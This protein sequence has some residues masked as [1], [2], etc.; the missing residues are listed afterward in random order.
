MPGPEQAHGQ[1]H[2]RRHPDLRRRC[3]RGAAGQALFELLTAWTLHARAVTAKRNK[4][5][6]A[7]AV[8]EEL[9]QSPPHRCGNQTQRRQRHAGQGFLKSLAGRAGSSSFLIGSNVKGA[10][11]LEALGLRVAGAPGHDQQHKDER[12]RL[13]ARRFTGADTAEDLFPKAGCEKVTQAINER[14]RLHRRR[15][16]SRSS[17][18]P[19]LRRMVS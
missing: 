18:K 2:Q 5:V 9:R 16:G 11:R 8:A 12:L 6:H 1:M 17:H 4:A 19:F 10:C 15:A 13:P 3:V 14:L 7:P